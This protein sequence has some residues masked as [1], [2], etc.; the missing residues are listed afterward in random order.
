MVFVR[1]DSP[2]LSLRRVRRN[3][4]LVLAMILS[5]M[6]LP[7]SV[8]SQSIVVHPPLVT[9]IR[10]TPQDP[11]PGY[12]V[13]VTATVNS[14][15]RTTVRAF[16]VY[17]SD[18]NRTVS[19]QFI[20]GNRTIGDFFGVIPANTTINGM[21]V[22]YYVAAIDSSGFQGV[23]EPRT[24]V[25]QLDHAPPTFQL[26]N[27]PRG[28][29]DT[30]I[31]NYTQVTV[32]YEVADAGSGVKQV[33]VEYSNST[34]PSHNT[35]MSIPLTLVEGDQFDGLWTGVIPPMPN[36]TVHYHATAADFAGN[37]AT[38]STPW[39][40]EI[41]PLSAFPPTATIQIAVQ[42]LNLSSRMLTTYYFLNI[43]SP[44]RYA[45][46]N[47][48]AQVS[49]NSPSG[50]QTDLTIPRVSGFYY[51]KSFT[52]DIRIY[53]VNLWP[54]D[55]YLLDVSITL[56]AS[57]FNRNNTHVQIFVEGPAG[58]L[59]ASYILRNETKAY[60]DQIQIFVQ[61]QLNRNASAV[62]FM[63]A[64]YAVFF[65]LGSVAWIR[66]HKI[67]RRLE[68]FIGLFTF[69]VVLFFT[70]SPIL[71]SEG[72]SE[73]IGLSVPPALLVG[74]IWSITILASGSLIVAYL[75]E[76]GWFAQVLR[77]R[78]SLLR[79]LFNFISASAALFVTWFFSRI[80][81]GYFFGVSQ[82]AY[83]LFAIP[84]VWILVLIAL[85]GP[86][87]LIIEL[88]TARW[89]IRRRATRMTDY[90][91]HLGRRQDARFLGGS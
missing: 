51:E 84:Q 70:L 7:H 88:D 42:N 66:P 37:T 85:F 22:Y 10:N 46:D 6:V 8:M 26:E 65:V 5:A 31:L 55:S 17:K 14:Y 80:F 69:V 13:N 11:P 27:P 40:Y 19:M 30:P 52:S 33:S 77:I 56:H 59:F 79:H 83:F 25:V 29:L 71:K 3:L 4:V 32:S 12:S 50:N 16:L 72:I 73:F 28:Y 86:P 1:D 76:G 2:A 49:T 75:I 74:L 9:N 90:R 54:F 44:S 48:F 61:I 68:L 58:A 35:T 81:V 41:A 91:E 45:S 21:R 89:A 67:S 57:G 78:R 39:H 15:P 38:S 47:L 18:K 24:F 53:D 43:Q 82:Y 23:S 20:N 63:Q 64:I 36:G 60:S 87:I 34:D 62:D